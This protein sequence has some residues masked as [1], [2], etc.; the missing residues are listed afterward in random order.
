MIKLK[1][2]RLINWHYFVN[3]TANVESITFLTGANGTGKS[4]VIDALQIV[5]LG[6]TTGRNFNK[7]ANERTGR[8]LRGYLRGETGEDSSGKIT[9]LR[10]GRFSSYI[11]LAFYDTVKDSEFTLGIVFDSYSNDTEEKHFFWLN[12]GFPKNGFTNSDTTDK[13]HARP[14]TYR[15]LF[16]WLS[17]NMDAGDYRFFDT[18]EQY[19]AFLKAVFGNLPDKYFTLFKKSVSF[20]LVKDISQFITEF[21]CDVDYKVDIAPM[22]KNIEQY[23]LLESESARV[24]AKIDQLL[25][26]H[27]AFED[28]NKLRKDMGTFYYVSA[29][30]NYEFAKKQL[31]GCQAKIKAH[32]DQ[33]ASI[34]IELSQLDSQI[35]ELGKEKDDYLAKKLASKDFSLS[36]S[37][38]E[39][40]EAYATKMASL[41]LSAQNIQK[42]VGNYAAT[43]AD[44]AE[45]TIQ[46]FN[47]IDLDALSLDEKQKDRFS[48][49]I[50]FSYEIVKSAQSVLA[51]C[52]A[53]NL[54]PKVLEGFQ[55]DLESYRTQGAA[56]YV[57]AQQPLYSLS[58][59]R[60]NLASQIKNVNSGVKPYAPIYKECLKALTDELKAR[61][62]DAKVTVFCDLVNVNDPAWV[63]AV[64]ACLGQAKFNVFVNPAYYNEAY[65]ILRDIVRRYGFYGLN[66]VDSDRVEDFIADHPAGYDSVAQLISTDDDAARAYADYLLGNVKK[67]E[68]FEEARD[69]GHGLLADC[70]GYRNFTTWYLKKPQNYFL[71]TRID[72]GS[73]QGIH[74]DYQKVDKM[75]SIW[76]SIQNHL[77]QFSSLG[78]MSVSEART[79]RDDLYKLNEI[80]DIEANIRRLED[81]MKEGALKDVTALDD[82]IQALANDISDLQNQKEA[83]NTE[84]G[85]HLSEVTRL[86]K[87]VIPEKEALL[88]K[89]K[90]ELSRYSQAELAEYG[91]VYDNLAKTMTIDQI[92]TEAQLRFSRVQNRQKAQRD[93]LLKLRQVYVTNYNLSY[94]VTDEVSN[95]PFDKELQ[96]LQTVLLPQYQ[97]Q[98]AEAHDNAIKEFKDDFI[99]KLRTLISTVQAQI[100]ELNDALKGV[101]FGRDS[102]RFTVTPNKDYLPYYEMVM[103]PLL[104]S[105]GDADE[106]FMEKYQDLM[107]QLF[108]LISDS[109]DADSQD[110]ERIMANIEKYTDYRTYLTFDFLVKRGF[111]KGAIE[112]S[113]ARTFSRQSGGET[114]T[115]IYLSI[116]ASFAQLYRA[117]QDADTL[118]LVILD[119]AFSKLDAVRIRECVG[120]LRTFG[121]QGIISTPPDKLNDLIK[122]VDEAL[123]AI[124]N[125]D[126]KISY[127]DLYQ[128]ATKTIPPIKASYGNGP[129]SPTGN[130]TSAQAPVGK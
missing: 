37:L 22:T 19:K 80:P 110:R 118:R 75:I 91:A 83:K 128:D 77:Y 61:H 43:Y 69:S 35:Q 42:Q 81:Q 36:K 78:N 70:T 16:D 38:S 54:D 76:S 127:L 12:A 55:K 13:E 97:K 130:E 29:R 1:T 126:R 64:E 92:H 107:N 105:S 40:K 121:L 86:Q 30:S 108:S 103:D 14:L 87:E 95:E 6:D 116:F 41:K 18:N 17:N 101:V 49:L 85:G 84:K 62:P 71:G 47:A 25:A 48:D 56:L 39:K 51:A 23:R 123:V 15:E 5:L 66:V 58:T 34:A 90:Q 111:G 93:N 26:I 65:R 4:T 45:K 72:M 50:Q 60:A 10:S 73:A 113:L 27:Q 104:L 44:L 117:S 46:R 59:E 102:Y 106:I 24:K 129:I 122:L 88:A 94:D 53:G 20:G 31:E 33:L 68:T 52:Q 7:A 109:Q 28:F 114:Q 32:Q 124:H 74:D 89:A 2:I 9:C 96:G 119:E 115:P 120:L 82:K 21:V 98:I 112:S 125:D 57:E 79:Y 67:C 8:T 11:A 3:T 99:Y 100:G 63:D